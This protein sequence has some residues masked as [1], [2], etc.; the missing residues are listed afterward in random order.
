MWSLDSSLHVSSGVDVHWAFDTFGNSFARLSFHHAA[1][2]LMIE[3]MLLLRRYCLD[4][5]LL[6]PH[7]RVRR[8]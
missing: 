7:H 5:P 8:L 4:E 1:D 6:S 3:R 2:E